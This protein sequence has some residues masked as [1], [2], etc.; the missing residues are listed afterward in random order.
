MIQGTPEWEKWRSG[1]IGASE[2]PAIIGVCPYNTPHGIWLVK[3][4][5][6]KG[7]EGN[8]FTEHGKVTEAAARARYELIN[9]EDMP[10]ACATHPTFLVCR[11]SLDGFNRE[12]RR[13]LEMKC[14]KGRQVI[15]AA[16]AGRV[17]EHYWP[18]V[19]YQ[20]A[21]TG[22]DEL[23]FFVFHEESKTH[24]LVR[25][26]PDVAYQGALIAAAVGFW[27]KY[28]L[29]NTPPPL[30]DRDVKIVETPDIFE[31]CESIKAKKDQ[32]PKAEIDRLKAAAVA[33]AGHPKM[34]CGNVQISTVNR[35]GKFSYHKLTIG[36][37]SAE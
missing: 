30:T 36:A 1:G 31:I 14:P 19:Q 6:S 35:N 18:Q 32:M 11:A 3:T 5:R 7:F 27:G 16:L 24:A 9:M 22:A 12:L 8:S 4:G 2:M 34:K 15:D 20:L 23:D 37:G 17:A 33:L 10:P 21:V 28:V 29:T 13:I 26:L 25:V